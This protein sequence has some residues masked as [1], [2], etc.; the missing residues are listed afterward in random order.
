[1]KN[2]IKKNL[3]NIV[4]TA[5]V[6]PILLVAYVSISHVTSF[7]GLSNPFSWAVYLSVAVEI[8]ALAALAGVSETDQIAF[9]AIKMVFI[10]FFDIDCVMAQAKKRG[11]DLT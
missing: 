5:F 9:S 4:A 1:M 6:I 7:Y 3:K 10:A 2:W 8:A 11:V